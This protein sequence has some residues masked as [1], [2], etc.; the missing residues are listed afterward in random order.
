[1]IVM[2]SSIEPHKKT[3]WRLRTLLTLGVAS[4]A[5]LAACGS[6]GGSSSDTTAAAATTAAASTTGGSGAAPT[7]GGTPTTAGAPVKGNVNLVAYSTPQAAYEA[8]QKAFKATPQGKDVNFTQSYG[9]SGDQSRA[10]AAGQPADLVAFSLEPDITRLVKVNMVADT[11]NANQYKGM[12]TNSVVVLA[13]RKGNPKHI[14]GWDDLVKPGI[15]VITPNVFQSGGAKWNIMAA[16]GAQIAEGKTE[17]QAVDYLK[18]L[19]KNVPV[20]DDSARKSLQTFTG[21]KGDVMIA[22]ENDAIFAQQKGA[23]IDYIVPP[24]TIL[25]ENPDAVTSNAKNPD[26]AKAFL[27]FLYTPA[28]QELFVKNGYRPV[29]PNIPGADKF[30]KPSGLF[31]ISKFGGWSTVNAKFFD[32]KKSIMQE[33]EASIGVSSSSS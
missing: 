9:A 26:A 14:T 1:L 6:S 30:P 15:E 8:I 29:L 5:I 31:D 4:T 3:G 23:A 11:W 17:A 24:S 12:V 22:Y 27:S 18:A 19:F 20:Q 25:I 16:Y 13:V 21:G 32:P 28:A 10:V 2:T 7:T 33:V